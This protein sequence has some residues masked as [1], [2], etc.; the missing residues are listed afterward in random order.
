MSAT[1]TETKLG[2]KAVAGW[3]TA[4]SAVDVAVPYSSETLSRQFERSEDDSLVGSGAMVPSV[5][6]NE[7]AQGDTS[8]ILDYNNFNSML[9]AWFGAEAAGVFTISET[10]GEYRY[11][12]LDKS[13]DRWRFGPSKATKIVISGQAGDWVK[14]TWSWAVKTLARSAT[15]FPAIS[16]AARNKVHFKNMSYFWIGDQADALGAG[17]KFAISAF[18][19]TLERNLVTDDYASGDSSGNET[20][21]LEP[22]G[23]GFRSASLK[24]T[25]PRYSTTT[26]AI[27]DWKDADT[28][29]QADFLFSL[30]GETFRVQIPNLVI[31][32]GFD[33]NVGGPERLQAEGTLMA[34]PS[35]AGHPM[36]TGNECKITIT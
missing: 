32:E 3:T 18:E 34:Y 36:Y 17:D 6:S 1:G 22:I 11:I 14:G 2:T 5:Q 8:H 19:L 29:L 28:A 27:I 10:L 4:Y 23:S 35:G 13:V 33:V 30:S 16:P 26:E 12:E 15:A 25:F 7:V 24:L 9:K 31:T 21:I 20:Q